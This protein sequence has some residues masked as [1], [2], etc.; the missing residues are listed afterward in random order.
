VIGLALAGAV[1]IAG[2]ER[3]AEVDRAR[4]AVMRS[5]LDAF[6]LQAQQVLDASGPAG[7]R[8]WLAEE[9]SERPEP[10]LLV[11]TPDGRE[12]L[13]RPLPP[14][15]ART[16]DF[17]LRFEERPAERR[18]APM[19]VLREAG[20]GRFLLFVPT[21][22]GSPGPWRTVREMP[23][24][25]L[26][27]ALLASGL[28]CFLLA[29]WLT[30]PIRALREAG[31]AIAA[32][33]LSARVGPGIGARSDEI[34]A[35]AREFD[36]MASR[37]E[38]LLDNQ[39]QLLRDVSHELRSPLT[40]LQAAIG[41]VRQRLGNGPDADLDRIEREA[42]RLDRLI[43]QILAYSRLQARREIERGVVDLAAVI[44]EVVE[45]ARFE[46]RSRNLVIDLAVDADGMASGDDALLRSAVENV[47]RNAVAHARTRV[48]VKLLDSGDGM[49][50]VTVT[51]D[52]PGVPEDALARLFEPFYQV[53]GGAG[54][55]YGLGL[56]ITAR[57]VALHAGT[58]RAS[59]GAA[60]GL[61]VAIALPRAARSGPV[62][63]GV[64]GRSG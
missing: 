36:R 57:A 35:L 11:I 34:G 43:G 60:G 62:Q 40:R 61:E 47:V 48:E 54:R 4:V 24:N 55:G 53:S 56:A 44:E 12:L 27:G 59:R 52:G 10:P 23:R 14:G 2:G 25:F 18:R 37:V 7:L 19:R 45:D 29:R 6:A 41:L 26:F 9:A 42:A 32:G 13:G 21:R 5:A 22:G 15:F 30:R 16:A 39:Q 31:S 28:V 8:R 38:S 51:D 58:V 33:N 63:P 46:A 50:L 1:L 17:M 20:G 64:S 49:S 3:R